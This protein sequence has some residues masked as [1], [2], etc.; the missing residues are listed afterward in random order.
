MIF[1][2]HIDNHGKFTLVDQPTLK[3]WIDTHK[4]KAI[5]LDIKVKRRKRTNLQNSFYWSVVVQYVMLGLR[6]LGH[7]VDEQETHEL[8]KAKFNSKNVANEH[9]EVLNIPQSTTKLNTVDMMDY[10]AKIQMWAAEFLNIVIPDPESQS[11]ITF[12][13]DNVN[14]QSILVTD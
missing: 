11:V 10:I 3:R 2:G 4:G 5:T 7:E 12:K 9:G 8:L 6:E 14:G 1:T 13:G